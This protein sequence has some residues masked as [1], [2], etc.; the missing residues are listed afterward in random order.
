MVI[1]YLGEPEFLDKT[2]VIFFLFH[3]LAYGLEQ[4]HGMNLPSAPIEARVS[5]DRQSK[6]DTRLHGHWLILARMLWIA[7]FILTLVVFC[8]NL[9]VGSYGLV[10]TIL[11]VAN[12]SV[13][14]AVSLVLFWRKS[15]DRAI[16][17]ISLPLVLTG[18]VFFPPLPLALR[19]YGV[20]WVP[21]D[22]LAL[23]AG[24]SL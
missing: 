6:G 13:W 4:G 2:V 10:T 20:W 12:T 16:L 8:A 5:T 24:V 21:I 7:I 11:L 23:L 15:T 14:F 3:H 22:I 9:I 19:N 1:Y 18:G 17:L